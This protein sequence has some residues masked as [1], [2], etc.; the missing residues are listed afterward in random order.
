MGVAGYDFHSVES[1]VIP[2][3]G[4]KAISIDIGVELREN[5]YGRIAPSSGLALSFGID[6]G[7]GVIE[8]TFRFAV[9]RGERFLSQKWRKGYPIGGTET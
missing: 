1:T 9:S 4:K 3:K 5:T 6:K 2:A 7:A 8:S